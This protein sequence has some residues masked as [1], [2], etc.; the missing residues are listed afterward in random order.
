MRCKMTGVKIG[1]RFETVK[2]EHIHTWEDY[3]MDGHFLWLEGFFFFFI[4]SLA[5]ATTMGYW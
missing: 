5:I 3:Q 1:G 2:C 4:A